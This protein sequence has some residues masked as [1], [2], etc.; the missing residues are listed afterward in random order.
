MQIDWAALSVE[1]HRDMPAISLGAPVGRVIEELDR[2]ARQ[3]GDSVIALHPAE[4]VVRIA[5]RRR[6]LGGEQRVGNLGLL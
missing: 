5:E 4:G 6:C 3:D 2:T 1:A